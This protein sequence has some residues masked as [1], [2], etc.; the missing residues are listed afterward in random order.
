MHLRLVLVAPLL[1]PF[2]LG[3][4]VRR[5][6]NSTATTVAPPVS[7]ATSAPASSQSPPPD[8]PFTLVSS[9]PTAYP[10]SDIVES[11]SIHPTVPLEITVTPG[12]SP[13]GISDAPPLPTGS[14][15]LLTLAWHHRTTCNLFPFAC[16]ETDYFYLSRRPAEGAFL[17]AGCPPKDF[18]PFNL[19]SPFLTIQSIDYFYFF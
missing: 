19:G 8:V 2:A 14:F 5:Q 18:R 17:L 6:D 15:H 9:N 12:E 13:T 7:G 3:A 1:A 4:H 10:L 11:P 16:R